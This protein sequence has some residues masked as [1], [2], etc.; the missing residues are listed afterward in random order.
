MRNWS[1]LTKTNPDLLDMMAKDVPAFVKKARWYGGK[2]SK[3]NSF[4]ADHLLPITYKNKRYYL[5]LIEILYEGGFVHN[6][7]LPIAKLHQRKVSNTEAIIRQVGEDCIIDATYYQGFR[8]ALFFYMV[9][10]KKVPLKTSVLEFTR[11]RLFRQ[12]R[13]KES[14]PSRLLKLEQSNTTI[15]YDDQLFCKLYRRLFRDQN[16]EVEMV[17]FL[18]EEVKFKQSPTFGAV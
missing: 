1:K 11:G 2:N 16:P 7:L 18:S 5:L 6:Y 9:Q 12:Y 8:D 3:D 15:V 10:G 13:E 4:N 17:Q 14:V